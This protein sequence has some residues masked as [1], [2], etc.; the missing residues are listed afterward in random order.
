MT[1]AVLYQV[2]KRERRHWFWF[3]KIVEWY[4]ESE[5]G[6]LGPFD[7]EFDAMT[8]CKQLASN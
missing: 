3:R 1:Y 8:A 4:I 5:F 2:V 7:S 6:A